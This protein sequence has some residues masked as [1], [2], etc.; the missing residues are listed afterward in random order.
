MSMEVANPFSIFVVSS[1]ML[2]VLSG[3]VGFCGTNSWMEVG[4]CVSTFTLTFSLSSFFAL[5]LPTV[6]SCVTTL[7]LIVFLV[8]YCFGDKGGDVF[9]EEVAFVVS[10]M[11][12]FPC[13]LMGK[14]LCLS[15]E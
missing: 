9:D 12:T 2:A 6:G 8:L 5:V 4:S 13:V 11:F 7:S 3:S 10:H 15:F 1:I 14:F